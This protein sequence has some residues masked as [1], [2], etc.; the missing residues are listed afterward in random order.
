MPVIDRNLLR[1]GLYELLHDPEIPPAV[2][3][4]E[5][6]ELAKELST[7]DSGRF[8]NGILARVADERAHA[9]TPAAPA[10]DGAPA[11][12]PPRRPPPR[13]RP[14]ARDPRSRSRPHAPRTAGVGPRRWVLGL[15]AAAVLAAVAAPAGAQAPG[16]PLLDAAVVQAAPDH[17]TET[18]ADPVD[19]ANPE[20]QLLIAAATQNAA[21]AMADGQLRWER[22]QTMDIAPVFAGYGPSALAAGR[23]AR[24]A[25]RRRPPHHRL[26]PPVLGQP[27]RRG[28][29]VGPVRA[30]PGPLRRG[31]RLRRPA[32]LA[33]LPGAAGR[34]LRRAVGAAGRRGPPDHRRGRQ[35]GADGPGLVPAARRRAGG[36]RALERGA[37]LLG[38]RRR[39]RQQH[40]RP[41]RLGP[42]GRGRR[43]RRLPRRVVPR[44]GLPVPRRRR[45][46]V[47]PADRDRAG[48]R[49]PGARR[50]RRRGLRDRGAR[51]RVGPR[52][53]RRRRP[54]GQRHRRA[55]RGRRP[56]RGQR[57]SL[58]RRPL[59]VPGH[60][61]AAGRGPL[62]PADGAH[63]PGGCVR[64]RLRARRRQPRPPAVG[65][66]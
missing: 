13:T 66:R 60:G 42:A 48:P 32:R 38:R 63:D 54:A 33:H 55:L 21:P 40:P 30:R 62:P 29:P 47:G 56:A 24:R 3:I 12:T 44:R 43:H 10:P 61:R 31:D 4:N 17:F 15:T 65:R 7:D 9:P 45:P 23:E 58:A 18:F 11:A 64:P 37:A 46:L 25:G 26:V 49:L 51:R 14:P 22:R 28:D 57:R 6:V 20:D 27:Q 39:P 53:A 2:A 41:A 59:P 52:P 16:P 19:Y 36:D 50:A 8:V 5:A 34:A 35:P 1:M